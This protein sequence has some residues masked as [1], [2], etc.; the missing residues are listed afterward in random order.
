MHNHAPSLHDFFEEVLDV[1]GRW[2]YN[3]WVNG[4]LMPSGTLYK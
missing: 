2:G 1:L 3:F 4:E